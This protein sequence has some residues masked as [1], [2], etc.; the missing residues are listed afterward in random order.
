MYTT[1]FKQES[2]NSLIHAKNGT[3]MSINRKI[4]HYVINIQWNTTQWYSK[5]KRKKPLIHVTWMNLKEWW[6][7]SS[8]KRVHA[9]EVHLY[10]VLEQSKLIHSKIDHNDDCLCSGKCGRYWLERG[11]EIFS[12]VLEIFNIL[13]KS[14]YY[15]NAN[16]KY[17]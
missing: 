11:M 5:K 3:K 9:C 6:V 12:G 16:D 10:E 4:D 1:L 8:T 14:A 13:V 2:Q 15:N 17:I 7:N